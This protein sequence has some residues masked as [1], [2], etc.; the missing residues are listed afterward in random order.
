[1]NSYMPNLIFLNGQMLN[2]FQL[3]QSCKVMFMQ[4]KRIN[5]KDEV[6]AVS[7][8]ITITYIFEK[9]FPLNFILTQLIL[10]YK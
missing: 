10:V 6:V 8:V 2:L 1:M 7:T 5:S 4:I 3:C 9:G